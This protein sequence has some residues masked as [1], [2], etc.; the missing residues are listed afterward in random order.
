MH[1]TLLR[2]IFSNFVLSFALGLRHKDENKDGPK[3]S[4][5]GEDEV[6]GSRTDGVTNDGDEESHQEWDEPVEGGAEG[7][8]DGPGLRRNELHVE[9]PGYGTEA[10]GESS[11][12]YHEGDERQESNTV[13]LILISSPDSEIR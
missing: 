3:E 9:Y 7:G 8:G 5:A 6:A 10:Q 1:F 2:K 12:E 4:D 11:D 13:H